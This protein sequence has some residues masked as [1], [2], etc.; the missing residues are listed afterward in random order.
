VEQALVIKNTGG[1]NQV[2]VKGEMADTPPG[3]QSTVRCPKDFFRNLEGP[4]FSFDKGVLMTKKTRI[5]DGAQVVGS[6]HSAVEA[7]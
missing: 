3:L 6:I 2:I 1:S 7:G 4:M 5:A